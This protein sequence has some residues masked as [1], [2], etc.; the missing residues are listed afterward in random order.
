[1]IQSDAGELVRVSGRSRAEV[2]SDD[3]P[4][5]PQTS[6]FRAP[7]DDEVMNGGLRHTSDIWR[8]VMAKRRQSRK[9]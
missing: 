2:V 7:D 8:R 1:M 9:S 6:R 5:L 3:R 4:T